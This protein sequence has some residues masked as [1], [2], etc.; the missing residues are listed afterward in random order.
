M[1]RET[2]GSCSIARIIDNRVTWIPKAPCETDPWIENC[3]QTVFASA[4][5]FLVN[6]ELE[7]IIDEKVLRRI[8]ILLR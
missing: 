6:G 5:A 2:P 8:Q 1:S 7:Q 4:S 3:F